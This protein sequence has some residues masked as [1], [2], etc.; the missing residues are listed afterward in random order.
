M[1][2]LLPEARYLDPDAWLALG[3]REYGTQAMVWGTV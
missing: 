2:T 1:L 3:E